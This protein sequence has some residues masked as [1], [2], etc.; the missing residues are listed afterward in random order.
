MSAALKATVAR[1]EQRIAFLEGVNSAIREENTALKTNGAPGLMAQYNAVVIE[2]DRLAWEC[3]SLRDALRMS[4]LDCRILRGT[5]FQSTACSSKT[6]PTAQSPMAAWDHALASR[7]S[8]AK[9]RPQP[10]IKQRWRFKRL[11]RPR[12]TGATS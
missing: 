2:R 10:L 5:R 7:A 11:I 1:L 4:E 8:K 3:S 12:R 6:V 9:R